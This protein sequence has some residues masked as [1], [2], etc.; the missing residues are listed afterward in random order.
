MAITCLTRSF[1]VTLEQPHTT[2]SSISTLTTKASPTS[3][4]WPCRLQRYQTYSAHSDPLAEDV[5]EAEAEADITAPHPSP[6]MPLSRAPTQTPRYQ[7]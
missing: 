4:S 1:A 2:S 7:G 5:V 6:T 3:T